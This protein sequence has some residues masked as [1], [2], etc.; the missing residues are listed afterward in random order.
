MWYCHDCGSTIETQLRPARC[1]SCR[2]PFVGAAENPSLDADYAAVDQALR[3]ASAYI[4]QDTD[5]HTALAEARVALRRLL[6][7]A[8]R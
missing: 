8:R 4:T 5:E 1:P 3:N 6:T 7:R 2:S